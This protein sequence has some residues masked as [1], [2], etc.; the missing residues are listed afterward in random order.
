MFTISYTCAVIVPVLSGA[1]WDVSG[2]AW[3]A[4]VPLGLCAIAY[5]VLGVALNRYR[6]PAA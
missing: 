3:T 6:A 5:T 2:A 4:F 1:I